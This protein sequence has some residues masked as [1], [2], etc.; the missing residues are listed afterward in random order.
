MGGLF[1]VSLLERGRDVLDV[2]GDEES[3]VL[4]ESKERSRCWKRKA[5]GA[6]EAGVTGI[7]TS[8][9]ETES[10][11]RAKRWRS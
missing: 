11:I 5:Q 6:L 7:E 1:W 10:N 4:A 8:P 9:R 3:R 2:G